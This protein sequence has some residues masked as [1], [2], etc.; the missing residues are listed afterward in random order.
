MNIQSNV[1]VLTLLFG[2]HIGIPSFSYC[3]SKLFSESYH[4]QAY[5]FPMPFLISKNI[6]ELS[7]FLVY[8]Q[9]KLKL[10]GIDASIQI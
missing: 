9:D 5:R 6:S 3:D 7:N 4:S 1:T 8:K 2:R 10:Q